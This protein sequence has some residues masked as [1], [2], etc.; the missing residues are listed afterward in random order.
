[1]PVSLTSSTVGV[2]PCSMSPTERHRGCAARDEGTT[3]CLLG[4][5][6]V[7]AAVLDHSN[8]F[9][10]HPPHF[11]HPSLPGSVLLQQLLRPHVGST[12]AQKQPAGS[13][14]KPGSAGAR[15]AARAASRCSAP[16]CL[17]STPKLLLVQVRWW[18]CCCAV[19]P[20]HFACGHN[21]T[22]IAE[23]LISVHVSA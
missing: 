13:G 23:S 17:T 8:D 10:H 14:T 19:T 4:A 20:K 3:T 2:F 18:N 11:Q 22:P 21:A 7:T 6:D 16:P 1:M 15:K 9:L 5:G 12:S